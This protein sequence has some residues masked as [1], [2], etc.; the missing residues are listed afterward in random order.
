[1]AILA[2]VA[3]GLIQMAI[4]RQR[5][6]AADT[7]GA[8][9]CGDP[10]YLA[11]AL[12]KIHHGAE[13][14]PMDSPQPLNALMIAE[15]RNRVEQFASLFQTHPPLEKRLMNLIGRESIRGVRFA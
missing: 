13:R 8:R 6:Y 2:P 5:E 11:S 12:E 7:E 15:P 3:A 14:I 10:M 1:M 4:S 9:I